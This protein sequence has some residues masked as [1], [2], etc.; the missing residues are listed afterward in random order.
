[1]PEPVKKIDDEGTEQTAGAPTEVPVNEDYLEPNYGELVEEHFEGRSEPKEPAAAEEPT[2]EPEVAKPDEGT[3]DEVAAE[4]TSAQPEGVVEAKVEEPSVQ[5]AAPAPPV[6]QPQAPAAESATEVPTAE[7]QAEAM[8]Q[9]EEQLMGELLKRYSFAPEEAAVL[10]ELGSKP[11]E[12]L[13]KYMA[14]AHK[15]IY[16]TVLNSMLSLLPNA[17]GE[18][19]KRD[20]AVNQA[21]SAFFERWPEL[22]DHY[23]LAAKSIAAYKQVDPQAKQADLIEQAGMIAMLKA[24]KN[25]SPKAEP[26]ATTSRAPSAPPPPA[27]PGGA[28]AGKPGRQSLGYE[29][30]IFSKMV[31]EDRNFG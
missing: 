13:P 2:P 15:E 29:E 8:K 11:S 5:A 6:P 25:P 22:K 4:Q 31:E 23:D 24:G 21:E 27:M 3:T 18:L 20:I 1:M 9:L 16:N 10:D 7:Q 14:K 28:T 19:T 17:V 12:Y 26:A 30:Q